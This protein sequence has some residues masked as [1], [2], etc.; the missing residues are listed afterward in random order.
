MAEKKITV[1]QTRSSIGKTKS[2]KATLQ[3]LGL[4][5][6]GRRA[7]HRRDDS[8]LGMLKKV[9]HMVEIQT[10]QGASE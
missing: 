6:I 1:V 4:G 8:I 2:Q 7:E 9:G 10:D 5:R 3:A